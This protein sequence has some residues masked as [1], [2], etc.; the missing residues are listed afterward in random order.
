MSF[1]FAPPQ[2]YPSGGSQPVKVATGT[3]TPAGSGTYTL[4][5][6]TT[7]TQSNLTIPPP[8]GAS[9][10]IAVRAIPETA[11][12]RTYTIGGIVFASPHGYAD[13]AT[14]TVL[15]V[16]VIADSTS[17]VYVFNYVAGSPLSLTPSSIVLPTDGSS[18]AWQYAVYYQ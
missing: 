14:P 1:P 6:G 18:G 5:G 12:A 2:G 7:Q 13:G 3:V 17:T 4:Y 11:V 15:A 16:G 10:I 8:A 9:T